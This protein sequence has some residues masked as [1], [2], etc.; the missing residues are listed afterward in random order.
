MRPERLSQRP[1]VAGALNPEIPRGHT[2]PTLPESQHRL[3]LPR[4]RRPQAGTNTPR[5]TWV[6][7]WHAAC[8]IVCVALCVC[9]S[10]CVCAAGGV[11]RIDL[12]PVLIRHRRAFRVHAVHHAETRRVAHFKHL[13]Q[14]MLRHATMR[15]RTAEPGHVAHFKHPQGATCNMQRTTCNMQHAADNMQ[16]ATCSGQHATCSGQ[17]AA[18]NMQHAADDMQHAT[19]SGQHATCNGQQTTANRHVVHC[20][21]PH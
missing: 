18:D 19:C 1:L 20:T 6:A 15:R 12:L 11:R 3:A 9:V 13:Q 2:P 17:H 14:S 7:T 4:A 5:C 8:C 21:R 16:H 10:V